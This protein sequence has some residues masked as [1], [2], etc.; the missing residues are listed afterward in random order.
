FDSGDQLEQITKQFSP[1]LFNANNGNTADFDT[2]SDNKGPEPEG[3]TVGIIDGKTYGFIGLER[4]AGG[5][6]VYDLTN[7]AAPTFIQYIYTPGDV[8]PEGLKFI[9]AQDSPSGKPLLVVANE[10]SNTVSVYDIG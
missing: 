7:P 4:S 10:D 2:R 8:A 5:V 3:V 6:M 1:Q 9:S